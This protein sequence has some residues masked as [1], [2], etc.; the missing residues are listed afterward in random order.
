VDLPAV[1][2]EHNTPRGHAVTSRHP[3]A[4]QR[5]VTLVHVTHFNDL[6]WDNEDCP[7][8][9]IPH[10]VADPGYRYTGTLPRTAVMINE[11]MRRGRVTG[12]D[13]LPIFAGTGPV[14]VFGIGAGELGAPLTGIGDLPTERLHAEVA[15]RRVYLHTARWTSLG[16]SLIE[17]MML[18]M[19]VVCLAT[20][21]AFRAVPAE[22]G[23]IDTDVD[24]LREGV[25]TFLHEP[26]LARV[27]GK[28]ARESALAEFGLWKF[29]RAWDSLLTETAE[30]ML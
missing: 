12:T 13:L 6:V 4:G 30:E 28:A 15:R 14:D 26:D 1:Y 9:V 29:L 21:E 27:A 16:L 19:P 2:V 11:P 24:R 10:G 7:T 20:T 23:V 22:A 8:T 17:A 25:R 3:L 18:G 5:A